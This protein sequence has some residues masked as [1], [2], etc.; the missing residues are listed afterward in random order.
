MNDKSKRA[1]K[2]TAKA[3]IPTG[4]VGKHSSIVTKIL[5]DLVGLKSNEALKIPLSELPN[6]KV[7]IRSA[8]KRGASKYGKNIGTAADENYLYV[9]NI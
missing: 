3:N 4:R 9:W 1:F 8:I 2:T 5:D 7:N 6:T